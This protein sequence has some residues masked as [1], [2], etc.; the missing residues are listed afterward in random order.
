MV[1]ASGNTANESWQNILE[2][3]IGIGKISLFDAS[4]LPVQIAAEIKNLQ[5]GDALDP[6][7]QARSSRFVKVA[8]VAAAEAY[9]HAGEHACPPERFGCSI[10][11]GIGAIQDIENATLVM[12]EKGYRRVSPFFIPYTIPNMAA[13]IV[14]NRFNLQGPN[15]CTTT[16]CAS[17][18]HAIGE[19]FLHIRSGMADMMLAGGAEAALG[20]IALVGFANMKSLNTENDN[21]SG[22][23]RPFDVSRDGFVMGEGAGMLVLEEWER[24]T[25]RGAKIYAELVGYGMSGDA[26]HITSPA[27][28]GRGAQACM[29]QALD[30]FDLPK[31]EIDYINAHGTSTKLND[32]NESLAISRVFGERAREIAIS[33]TKG[34]TGHCLGAAGG[35]EAVFTTLALHHQICP[36][37]ANLKN[38]D[39]EMPT[40]DYVMHKPK[41]KRLRYALSNSFGFGG[42]NACLILKSIP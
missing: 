42:T 3:G 6:K 35:I 41:E 5:V 16:A 31:G 40:L 18:T 15:I 26:Y 7:E 17:G 37:T 30:F 24:A 36:H 33:S 27:P 34:A 22:A 20:P 14:S 32:L 2:G 10:G 29:Q 19:A 11:V 23:S 38:L 28:E 21:P 4:E 1:C 12:K 9:R 39:P 13:G 8:A 25:K